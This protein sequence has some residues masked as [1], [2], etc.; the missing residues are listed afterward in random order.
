MSASCRS[1]AVRRDLD[2]IEELWD[3]AGQGGA[4][5]LFGDFG[6]ADAFFAP[7]AARIATYDLPV[8]PA[9]QAYVA[10]HLADP[11]FRRWRAVG[12]IEESVHANYDLDLPERPWPGPVP[13]PAHAVTDAVPVNP[14]CPFSGKPVEPDSLAEVAGVVIGFCNPFCR[15]KVVADA[16]AWPQVLPLIGQS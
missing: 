8:G 1:D 9:A 6:I 5:W 10:L 13:L 7:V 3:Y 14:A 4:G 12:L 2:R 16:E 11:A 15:D